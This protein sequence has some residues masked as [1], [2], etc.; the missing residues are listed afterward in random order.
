M[1]PLPSLGIP[2]DDEESPVQASVKNQAPAPAPVE[3]P[4][5][6]TSALPDAPELGPRDEMMT[7]EAL[8]TSLPPERSGPSGAA[9]ALAS[10]MGTGLTGTAPDGS[11]FDDWWAE[12][13]RGFLTAAATAAN[14]DLSSYLAARE[15]LVSMEQ[16]KIGNL[17][18]GA[19]LLAAAGDNAGAARQLQAAGSFMFPGS[20]TEVHADD[21]EDGAFVVENSDPHTGADQGGFALTVPDIVEMMSMLNDPLEWAKFSWDQQMDR[22][23]LDLTARAQA[24]AARLDQAQLDESTLRAQRERVLMQGNLLQ[25]AFDAATYDARVETVEAENVAAL[26]DA[27]QKTFALETTYAEADQEAAARQLT[28]NTAIREEREAQN[29]SLSQGLAEKDQILD[30]IMGHTQ[31]EGAD[32]IDPVEAMAGQDP[33]TAQPPGDP[34]KYDPRYRQVIRDGRE[35]Y[36]LDARMRHME[37]RLFEDFYYSNPKMPARNI[38]AAINS[39]LYAEETGYRFWGPDYEN[40][41]IMGTSYSLESMAPEQRWILK[42]SIIDA[43]IATMTAQGLDPA[44]VLETHGD[45]IIGVRAITNQSNFQELMAGLREPM[46]APGEQAEPSAIANM[47]VPDWAQS[48]VTAMTPDSGPMDQEDQPMIF[49]P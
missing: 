44:G 43:R 46:Y 26:A 10:G 20:N 45:D 25:N 6:T 29:E 34:R 5:P 27:A 48:A 3:D 38:A 41:E 14:G 4:A 37:D 23:Q 12:Q 47:G 9:Q 15:H 11:R 33:A 18:N 21:D 19:L 7:M 40:V 32:E 8:P 42:D 2:E 36:V 39:L 28:R 17:M 24:R 30:E 49:G 1:D 31:P 22:A 16:Q 35:D 13:K